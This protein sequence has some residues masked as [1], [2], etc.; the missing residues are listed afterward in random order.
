VLENSWGGFSQVGYSILLT[1]KD[2]SD[3]CP[4]CQVTDVTIRYSTIDHVG[5]GLQIAT[6]RSSTGGMA[7]AGE[8]FSIHDITLGDINIKHY[9]GAGILVALY[10]GWT[11]NVLNNVSLDHITGFTDPTGHTF[12][13]LDVAPN[14]AMSAFKFT[15]SI[16]GATAGPVW[17]AGGGP[18]N[19]AHSN[20][21][22]TSLS[23]CFDTYTFSDNAIVGVSSAYPVSKWPAGNYFPASAADVQFANFSGGDYHLLPSS[24][25]KNIG[26]DGKN[27]GADLDA[28][29]AAIQGVY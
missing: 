11:R 22:V 4:V 6:A 9:A 28:I 25:L 26:T 21:P 12:V 15:N 27:L 8:R 24:N 10:N 1:P 14:P 23:T 18:G 7:L 20:V 2:Q 19:C 5:A 16:V 17:S 3:L 13:F 29:Q